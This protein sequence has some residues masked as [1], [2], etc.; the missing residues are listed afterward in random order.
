MTDTKPEIQ[1]AQ[2]E[3][4]RINNKKTL[5]RGMIVFKLP[6]AEG[7]KKRTP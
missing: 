2:R 3:Q 5:H 6:K 4:N 7:K 1:E